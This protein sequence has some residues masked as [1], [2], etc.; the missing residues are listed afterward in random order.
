MGSRIENEE[1]GLIINFFGEDCAIPP[2]PFARHDETIRSGRDVWCNR[3]SGGEREMSK[4]FPDA[5][6]E[7]DGDG[8]EG[9]KDQGNNKEGD[10]RVKEHQAKKYLEING[11]ASDEEETERK[12]KPPAAAWVSPRKIDNEEKSDKATEEKSKPSRSDDEKKDR[13]RHHHRDDKDKHDQDGHRKKHHHHHRDDHQ[14]KHH[15]HHSKRKSGDSDSDHSSSRTNDTKEKEQD[16][17]AGIT[18]VSPVAQEEE[19]E[20]ENPPG[21][22]EKTQSYVEAVDLLFRKTTHTIDALSQY[23]P[24]HEDDDVLVTITE[25]LF[26]P[27]PKTLKIFA[28]SFW[29]CQFATLVALFWSMLPC[30]D[31]KIDWSVVI[32][33]PLCCGYGELS[34]PPSLTPSFCLLPFDFM[35]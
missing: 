12:Q 10:H 23:M 30:P 24:A 15:H 19:G 5:R 22:L 4:I 14:K 32:G 17:E 11:S 35:L 29:I 20:R 26:K 13:H 21:S 16:L 7:Q 27:Y 33:L 1:E 3:R 31:Q 25:I 9:R 18:I 28:Y 2:P 6:M 8:E 34:S